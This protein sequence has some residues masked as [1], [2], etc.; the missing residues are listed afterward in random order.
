MFHLMTPFAHIPA[1][2]TTT[3]T[4]SMTKTPSMALA[5]VISFRFNMKFLVVFSVRLRDLVVFR[6]CVSERYFL[7]Q[8]TTN[9]ILCV[10]YEIKFQSV[11]YTHTYTCTQEF[12][13]AFCQ[14]EVRE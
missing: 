1:K 13:I 12:L 9:M 5:E 10:G 3:T 14:R 7:S 2:T 11:I 6:V 4:T 8:Q